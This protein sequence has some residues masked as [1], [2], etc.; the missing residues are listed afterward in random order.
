MKAE[1]APQRRRS[2]RLLQR[3]GQGARAALA[4]STYGVALF[5][6][7]MWVSTHDP[8][9]A[10]WA[11]RHPQLRG[12]NLGGWLV[13]ERWLNYKWQ[14]D[15]FIFH[16]NSSESEEP[17]Y[18]QTSLAR[19]NDNATAAILEH[20]GDLDGAIREMLEYVVVDLLLLVARTRLLPWLARRPQLAAPRS[21]EH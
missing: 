3:C 8:A 10:R 15:G 6:L 2:R 21:E 1:E 16:P 11:E 12:V 4:F 13:G 9:A 14:G 19:Q 20:R 18:Y 7:A 17:D 5:L